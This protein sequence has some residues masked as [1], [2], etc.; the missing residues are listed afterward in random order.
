MRQLQVKQLVQPGGINA[1]FSPG[2]LVDIEYFVQALQI[3]FGG[4]DA[5]LRTPNTMAALTALEKAGRID[6][7]AAEVLR[8]GHRF[9]RSLI[10]GLR[11][12]HG[13]AHDVDVPAASSEEFALLAR[14]LRRFSSDALAA[15]IATRLKADRAVI[16]RL[17]SLLAGA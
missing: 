13:N 11:V 10:D 2:A 12:V 17:E 14:R 15:E 4:R 16:D 5:S 7:D 9:F 8:A 3:A 1:K 6:A